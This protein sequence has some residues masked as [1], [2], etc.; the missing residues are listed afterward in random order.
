[1][2]L[3]VSGTGTLLEVT[4]ISSNVMFEV[5]DKGIST[6]YPTGATRA[7]SW[8]MGNKK[9]ATVPLVASTTDYVEIEI[10]G[11]IVKLAVVA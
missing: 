6:A 10:N 11:A 3:G 9:T 7:A 8:R 4:D 5:T 1:M 2:G